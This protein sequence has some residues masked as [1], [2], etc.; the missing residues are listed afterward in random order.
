MAATGS[1]GEFGLNATQTNQVR[2]LVKEGMKVL[3]EQSQA[4]VNEVRGQLQQAGEAFARQS[5]QHR[6][7]VESNKS[8]MEARQEEISLYV[9]QLEKNWAALGGQVEEQ[10]SRT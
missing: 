2:E 3:D 4:H 1:A 9:T 7:Q 6:Q 10:F 8:E 5:L